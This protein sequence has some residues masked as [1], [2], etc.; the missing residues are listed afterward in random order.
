MPSP[1]SRLKDRI[2]GWPRANPGMVQTLAAFSIKIFG[3]V[4]SFGFSLLIARLFGATGTGFF[5]LA[6]TTATVASTISL[7]GLDYL[8]LRSVSRDLRLG[9]TGEVRGQV[10]TAARAVTVQ[11][12]I[13]AS[14][15]ALF[16]A[17]PLP[18]LLHINLQPRLLGLAALAVVPLA[19]GRVALAVL[20]G[21]GRPV[22][23]Q[24]IDGP[25]AM[26]LT[27]AAVLTVAL[28][29]APGFGAPAA[30]AVHTAAVLLATGLGWLL[31]RRIARG[32]PAAVPSTLRSLIAQSWRLSAIALSMLLADWLLLLIINER[33]SAAE[34][35]QYRIAWQIVSL[36][37]MVVA[38][39]ETV[40]GPQVSAA[41]GVQDLAAIRRIYRQS[42]KVMMALSAPLFILLFAAP[43]LVLGLFGP[44]FAGAATALRILAFGQLLNIAAGPLGAVIIMTGHESWSLRMSGWSLLLIAVLGAVL[45]PPLGIIGAALTSC[46]NVL[47]RNVFGLFIVRRV[48]FSPARQP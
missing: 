11:A 27:L 40:A 19:L 4:I 16:A 7:I 12:G 38:T 46:A 3:A 1:T 17:S 43:G 5:A 44:E 14:L 30:F 36:I 45:I 21:A 24:W 26:L 18:A 29:G 48:I 15:L 9:K 23:A 8:L 28:I 39:F 6:L 41:Y 22:T 32:W 25:A 35:G 33:A 2:I 31:V 13:A 20:R 34:V 47:F 42:I 10:R 37:T